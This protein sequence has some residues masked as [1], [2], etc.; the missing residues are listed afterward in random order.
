MTRKN[1]HMFETS[2]YLQLSSRTHITAV[3]MVTKSQLIYVRPSKYHIF[4]FLTSLK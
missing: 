1:E 4:L 3:F 2:N